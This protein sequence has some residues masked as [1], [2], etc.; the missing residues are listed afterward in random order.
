MDFNSL[1]NKLA[2]WGWPSNEI[3]EESKAQDER[4]KFDAGAINSTLHKVVNA[5]N[6][7]K[8]PY[9][10]CGGIAVHHYGY[11]NHTTDVDFVVYDVNRAK[12]T[13]TAKGFVPTEY[14]DSVQ[15]V[16][17]GVRVDLMQGGSVFNDDH[18]VTMPDPQLN[19]SNSINYAELPVLISLKLDAARSKDIAAVEELIKANSLPRDYKVDPLMKSSYETLW[20]SLHTKLSSAE[21]VKIFYSLVK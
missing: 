11:H 4:E 3:L 10:V 16:K 20:D 2:D 21:R 18:L 1:L 19:N 13:L 6:K 14:Y 15:D 17:S 8:I 12:Q 5:F 9:Y 7:D